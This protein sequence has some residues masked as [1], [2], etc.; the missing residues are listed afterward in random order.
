MK[1]DCSALT[2][3]L[4]SVAGSWTGLSVKYDSKL[5]VLSDKIE[6]C[7]CSKGDAASTG[8]D[9]AILSQVAEATKVS[10]QSLKTSERV[11]RRLDAES[12]IK[13]T[14]EDSPFT[15]DGDG[16]WV[17]AEGAMFLIPGGIVIGVKN[18]DCDYGE[19]VLSVDAGNPNSPGL[20][21]PSGD[22]AVT[23]GNNNKATR[24]AA[25][26]TGGYMNEAS[27]TLC[28]ITGGSINK[29]EGEESVISGGNGNTASGTHSSVSGGFFNKA[30]GE[31]SSVA[32]GHANKAEGSY[33]VVSGGR[34]NT[35]KG[36]DSAVSGGR[37]NIAIGEESSIL[38]GSENEA[39]GKEA[40]VSGGSRNQA[41]GRYASVSGGLRNTSEGEYASILGGKRKA[42]SEDFGIFP[43]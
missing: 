6:T 37:K 38:G 20:N 16:W 13:L 8:T 2:V 21:C 23:F 3:I 30:K 7:A 32:G 33:S 41:L 17:A 10:T 29:C 35:A 1:F 4:V 9:S 12:G 39:S 24:R 34:V 43:Q 26:V 25:T 36:P 15:K 42:S 22:G 11:E 14:N 5:A 40:T 19:G 31:N 28:S 27:G 18:D